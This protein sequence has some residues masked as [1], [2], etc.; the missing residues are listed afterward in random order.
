MDVRKDIERRAM[1]QGAN[2]GESWA[3]EKR[4]KDLDKHAIT[5]KAKSN[6]EKKK[7]MAKA[8]PKKHNK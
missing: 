1:E 3:V 7:K 2:R 8:T 6:V 4:N 5:D